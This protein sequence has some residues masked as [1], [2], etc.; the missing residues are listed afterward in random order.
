MEDKYVFHVHTKRC[1]HA[2]EIEDEE[3]V[4]RALELGSKSIYFTDHGP[5]P[6][7]P[8]RNRMRYEKLDEYILSLKLLRDKYMGKIRIHIGIEIE[9]LPSYD[10]YYKQLRDMEDIE[11]LILGQ[12]HAETS[13]GRYTFELE[14]K[15]DEWRYLMEGQIAGTETGYFDVVAHPDRLFKREKKWTL[16]MKTEAERFIRVATKKNITI[17]KNI[18]SMHHKNQYWKEFWDLVPKDMPIV[19]GSDAHCLDDIV[20]GKGW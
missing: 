9:Y 8:F 10:E 13:S 1:G 12:H 18:A 16:D 4:K 15:S 3:Y 5:F 20:V 14:D 17:E 19:I 11:I 7:N 2:E 6:N